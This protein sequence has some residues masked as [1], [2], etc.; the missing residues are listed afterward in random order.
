MAY[1]NINVRMTRTGKSITWGFSLRQ[2]GPGITVAYVERDSMADKSGIQVGDS[3]E[4]IFG[5]KPGNLKE[6]Q[7]RIQNS[8]ELSLVLKRFI[9]NPPA[10]PWTL[11]DSG[12]QVIVNK[13]DNNGRLTNTY[14][15]VSWINI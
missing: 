5:S 6:V 2:S 15:K 7:D 9:T 12:N 8:N 13:Y 4:Q 11:E 1:E 3:V 10:L 14:D